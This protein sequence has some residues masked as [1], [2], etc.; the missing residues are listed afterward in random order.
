MTTPQS[1]PWITYKTKTCVLGGNAE[2]FKRLRDSID[3]LIAG[4]ANAIDIDGEEI[5][6]CEIRIAERPEDIPKP[7]FGSV[8]N[9]IAF[10]C[11]LTF[12]VILAAIGFITSVNWL[13]SF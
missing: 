6:I 11:L 9:L 10:I 1:E 13:T 7:P 4:E 2:G 5:E 3:R 12:F 8:R